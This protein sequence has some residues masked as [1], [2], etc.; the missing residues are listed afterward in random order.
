MLHNSRQYEPNSTTIM[1]AQGHTN[2]LQQID[3]YRRLSHSLTTIKRQPSGI[4]AT[5][6]RSKNTIHNG[7][8]N[9]TELFCLSD[10]VSSVNW[11]WHSVWHFINTASQTAPSTNLIR[12]VTT[13]HWPINIRKIQHWKIITIIIIKSQCQ[14]TAAV[15]QTYS[16]SIL[17]AMPAQYESRVYVSVGRLSVSLSVPAWARAANLAAGWPGWQETSIDC[18]TAHSSA[19]HGRQRGQCHVV[20]VHT[21]V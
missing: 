11:V 4:H 12:L 19:A 9:S 17:L 16:N 15:R 21:G 8:P 6:Q 18:C 5:G 13:Q 20:N 2:I 14:Q 10:R 1:A 3:N 7:Q